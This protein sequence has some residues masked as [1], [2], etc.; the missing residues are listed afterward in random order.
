M[1]QAYQ[2]IL[3]VGIQT[4]YVVSDDRDVF[5]PLADFYWNL[6]LQANIFMQATSGEWSIAHIGPTI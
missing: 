5:V 6:G 2:F 3:D 1:Q 4:I